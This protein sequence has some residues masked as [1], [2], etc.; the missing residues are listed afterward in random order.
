MVGNWQMVNDP[1]A[2]GSANPKVLVLGFSKG[3]TQANAYHTERFE[4]IPF[5]QMRNRLSAA[6]SSLSIIGNSEKV[7]DRM[8]A[9]ESDFA[10]GSLVRCS[11]SRQDEH[12]KLVCTG[13]VMPKAF[14]ESISGKL[15]TCAEKFLTRLPESLQLVLMLGTT[16][17]YIRG[18][19]SV[20]RSLHG[21]NF[22][23]LNE[24]SYQTG[25]VIWTHV[26]HPSPLNGHHSAWIAGDPTTTPGRKRLLAC[27]A[28]ALSGLAR[29]FG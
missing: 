21:Q 23:D 9:T 24:V 13:Q 22:S 4:D 26:S 15:R 28:V 1:G 27:D 25:R 14:T 2:W 18:C 12:G 29:R 19:R 7:E 3:F 10:F 16:E 11:L 20:V 8:V 6:L 5:K 17:T